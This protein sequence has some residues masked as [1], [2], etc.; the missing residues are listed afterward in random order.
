MVYGRK[1]RRPFRGLRR[2]G[3]RRFGYRGRG[4]RRVYRSRYGLRRA[5]RR[6]YRSKFNALLSPRSKGFITS[7]IPSTQWCKFRYYDMWELTNPLGGSASTQFYI[8]NVYDP[9]PGVSTAV[10]SG[11][12]AMT[13]LYNRFMVF[14]C[15]IELIC[16]MFT[17]TSDVWVYIWMPDSDISVGTVITKDFINES[18]L[19]LRSRLVQ[20]TV[21]NPTQVPTKLN[22]YR[23]IKSVTHKKELEPDTFAGWGTSGPNTQLY[24]KI[25]WVQMAGSATTTVRM[26]VR[27]TYY[28]MCFARKELDA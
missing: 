6:R 28:T 18:P 13:G 21:L 3:I 5:L 12:T 15:K 19:H 1:Y 25:G 16:T 8:N 17:Q 10:C 14:G 4:Y 23:S 22:L 20:S 9:I 27:I 2:R 11:F 7:I 26:H 24:G